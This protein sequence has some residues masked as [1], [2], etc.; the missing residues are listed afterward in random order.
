ML[1]KQ[2]GVNLLSKNCWFT[3]NIN[4]WEEPEGEEY[5]IFDGDQKEKTIRAASLNKLVIE[6]TSEETYGTVRIHLTHYPEPDFLNAFLIT[7]R[8]FVQP[9]EL[10]QKLLERY[11]VPPTVNASKKKVQVRVCIFIKRWIEK[12]PEDVALFLD[13]LKAFIEQEVKAE[14]SQ[15]VPGLQKAIADAVRTFHAEQ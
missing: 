14:Y 12:S 5:I 2:N 13:R 4:I 9:E 10:F 8:S 6:L 11:R 3:D 15:V 7:Y 1:S